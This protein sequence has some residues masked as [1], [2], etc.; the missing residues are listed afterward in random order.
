M[1]E[2]KRCLAVVL[3]LGAVFSVPAASAHQIPAGCLGPKPTVTFSAD[4]L[5]QTAVP[6]RDGDQLTLAAH[7][8]N[9]GESACNLSGLSI[10]V[11]PPSA[12]EVSSD[13]FLL[14]DNVPLGAGYDAEIINHGPYV[15]DLA[16]DVFES[17]LEL[18][19]QA[20]IHNGQADETVTGTGPGTKLTVTRPQV[21]LKVI[22]DVQSGP[23]PLTVT[24][25]YLLTNTSPVPTAG[26][27]APGLVP[28]G[29]N[30]PRDVLADAGCGPLNYLSG[31]LPA[32][33]DPVLDPGETW[34]FT[35]L[36]TY[37]LPG[38]YASQPVITGLSTADGRAW[39]EQPLG[40]EPPSVTALGP[41]LVVAKSH[42]GDLLAGS[43]G[44]Y[45]LEVT[46]TG[47]QPTDGA[48]T[49]A[50]QLPAGLT[51]TAIAGDGWTCTLASLSC[52][53]SDPLGSGNSYPE[54]TVTVAVSD[55]PPDNLVNTATVSGGGEPAGA[56]AN[57]LDEDP[58]TVR[59]P[60]QPTPPSNRI[61]KVRKVTSR[62]DG[63]AL[64]KVAVP[65]AGVVAADDA[66]K[67]DLVQRAWQKSSKARTVSLVVKA[68]S[69]LR[70]ALVASGKP[71]QVR[72]R[73]SFT[74]KGSPKATPTTSTVR[75]ISFLISPPQTLAN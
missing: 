5:S 6:L 73:I 33:T 45:E 24:T 25:V 31:D 37:P 68:G 48:V 50:D 44:S 20:T 40:A 52:S 26:T 55:D 10:M 22:P 21:E 61:F 13:H 36:R 29:S 1:R 41:D 65:G 23:A 43:S 66:G 51:G 69:K 49:V 16:D 30:G 7:V 70:K 54:V 64:I 46:N 71:R 39:P 53:R 67:S 38:T 14:I 9:K 74:A 4:T 62:G 75:S 60:S 19:W 2:I 72:V 27:P 57:N 56:V 12:D 3:A 47:N 15:V 58:T 32:D 28:T 18:S 63:S 8:D 42:Q 34:I 59:I 17:Q 11:R 35:C